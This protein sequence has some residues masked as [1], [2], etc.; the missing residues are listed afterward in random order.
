[1]PYFMT[2]MNS[3]LEA[4]Q[5]YIFSVIKRSHFQQTHNNSEICPLFLGR[6][7]SFILKKQKCF[8]LSFRLSGNFHAMQFSL[9]SKQTS[10]NIVLYIGKTFFLTDLVD[11]LMLSYFKTRRF[12]I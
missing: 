12:L 5:F 2:M 6:E 4:L 11:K 9:E 7:Q 1:M 3:Y 10:R 8:W